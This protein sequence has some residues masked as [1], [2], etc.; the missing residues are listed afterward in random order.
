[1]LAKCLDQDFPCQNSDYSNFDSIAASE[2]CNPIAASVLVN[3]SQFCTLIP[4]DE[5]QQLGDLTHKS[6]LRGLRRK[7]GIYHLWIDYDNCDDHETNTMICVYVGKGLAEV[8]ID[9][10]VRSIWPENYSL[11]VTFTECINRLAKYYEQLFLDTYSF[12][13]NRNENPGTEKLYAV[14]S[15]ELHMHGTELDQVSSLHNIQSLD[16]I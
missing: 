14:W 11:Y 8:R 3:E 10:H 13:L 15:E 9:D 12:V 4:T 2:L 1:M 6:Y 7:T 16:D 5:E